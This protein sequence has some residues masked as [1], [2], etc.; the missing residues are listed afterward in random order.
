[1]RG[2]AGIILCVCAFALVGEAYAR[3]DPYQAA[4]AGIMLA[5]GGITTLKGEESHGK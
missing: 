1:M 2:I 3:E 4:A 5:V